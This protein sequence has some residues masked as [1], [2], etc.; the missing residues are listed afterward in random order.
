MAELESIAYPCPAGRQ[1][2]CSECVSFERHQTVPD[3]LPYDNDSDITQWL[4]REEIQQDRREALR[5][6]KARMRLQED[7]RRQ[8]EQERLEDPFLEWEP[9]LVISE[10]LEHRWVLVYDMLG[11]D[12]DGS[13]AHCEEVWSMCIRMWHVGLYLSHREGERGKLFITVAANYDILRK[14]ASDMELPMRLKETMV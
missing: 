9:P 7:A 2:K 12:A 8:W 13:D 1:C 14:Q 10:R 4:E 3:F 11:A 6:M 5:R